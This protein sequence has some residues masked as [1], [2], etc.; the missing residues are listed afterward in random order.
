[1]KVEKELVGMTVIFGGEVY[2]VLLRLVTFQVVIFQQGAPHLDNLK[3]TIK[4]A[5]T[6]RY[7]KPFYSC[8]WKR[9]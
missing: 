1:M 3:R 2:T 7:N 4:T 6:T 9:G 8:G 5:E